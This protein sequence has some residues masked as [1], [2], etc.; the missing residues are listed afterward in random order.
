M[1]V[2]TGATRF[3]LGL[4][5]LLAGALPGIAA[6][7]WV[8]YEGDDF[9]E[10]QGWDRGYGDEV[11][12][13]H[14]GAVRTLNNGILG[15]DGLRNIEIEDFYLR[16]APADPEPGEAFVAEWRVR[17]DPQ[18]D[19]GDAGITIARSAVPGHVSFRY[20]PD[21]LSISPGDLTVPLTPG[22]FHQFRLV[23]RDMLTYTLQVD[24]VLT[25]E[26]AFEDFT[27]LQAYVAFGDG[28]WG[29]K[30]ASQ[31]DYVRFGIVPE[32]TSAGIFLCLLAVRRCR[33]Q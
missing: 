30:S 17:I 26:S 13:E 4:T 11:G 27:L 28:A 21:R 32:P 7:F 33:A 25:I 9:P 12:W 10:N 18:S 8:A 22:V 19:T 24:E 16:D 20:G 15:L 14:G 1:P 31:W 6:P 5:L 2:H 3:A 29:L 23:S